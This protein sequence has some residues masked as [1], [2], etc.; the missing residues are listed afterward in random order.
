M[1]TYRITETDYLAAARLSARPSRKLIAVYVLLA[2]FVVA[3]SYL[4]RGGFS[5]EPF[6]GV[7]LA[8]AAVVLGHILLVPLFARRAFRKYT[9]IQDN[10]EVAIVEEGLVFISSRGNGKVL[11]KD[12][13][14]WRE[15][16]SYI[17]VYIAP[18][19]FHILPKSLVSSG[20]DLGGLVE[21]LSSR[22]GPAC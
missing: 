7:A 1:A 22:V 8:A 15:N 14:K 16:D 4:M 3:T 9:A 10:F 2:G 17:L 21:R 19:L 11:W 12:M 13:I 5:W 20:F 18:Q 6:A